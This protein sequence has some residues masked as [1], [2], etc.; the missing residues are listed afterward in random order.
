MIRFCQLACLF[1]LWSFQL[2][3]Q[4]DSVAIDEVPINLPPCDIVSDSIDPFD[5]LRTVESGQM[6]LGYQMIS[7]YE[8]IDGPRLIAE[9]KAA[10]LYT[11]LDSLSVLFLELE[12]PEYAPH[13]T[14][15]DYNVKLKMSSD[16]IIGFYTV[17][18][19]G[20]FSRQTN[21][22]HYQH[23]ALVPTDLYYMLTY[24]QV[25]LIRI[26]YKSGHRRTLALTPEQQ[27]Q[28]REHFRC[29]GERVGYYPVSP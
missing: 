5:S 15:N 16:T 9:A 23:I 21:M 28:L 8:T 14:A 18:D 20:T 13:Q 7:Q 25:E 24:E 22:Q 11:E 12:L 2:S 29:V 3:A 17:S 10:V 4:T 26:E 1:V 6:A 27:L 19:R